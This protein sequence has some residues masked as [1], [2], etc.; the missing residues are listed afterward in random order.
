[1]ARKVLVSVALLVAFSVFALVAGVPR[2]DLLIVQ[3]AH[4]RVPNPGNT[5]IFT[6]SWRYPDR[7]LH[8]LVFRPLWMVDPAGGKVINVLAESKPI[9]N[10]DFTTMTVKLR[11]GI[12]WSDGVEFTADD[13]VYAVKLTIQHEG[14]AYHTQLSEWVKDVKALDR[15]TVVFDLK[16]PNPRFHYYFVDRWGCWRPFPKHIFEKVSDPVKFSFY[17]PIGTGAYILKSYDPAGYW[18]LY[19]R[20]KDW[21]R[22]PVGVLYGMPKPRYIL[23]QAYNS[24]EQMVL[25]MRKH[26][27]DVAYTF[28][29]ELLRSVLKIPTV[30]SF[31]KDFPWGSFV[32]PT[33][34]GI[35]LNTAKFPFNIRDVRWALTLSVNIVEVADLVLNGAVRLAP[36]HVPPTPLYMKYYYEPLKS[37]LENFEL[38][39]GNG[40][41]FKPFD[42]TIPEKLAKLAKE[43]GYSVP[44]SREELEKLFGIGW[45]K[46]A[47]DVAAKLLE[48][49][50]FKRNEKGQ[51]LLPNGQPWKIE[52][53]VN[54]DPNRADNRVPTAIAQQWQKFG[55]QV[56]IRPNKNHSI[57]KYGRFDASSNWPAVEPWGGNID[58]YR[59]IEPFA[60]KYQRPIGE[61]NP[62]HNSRWSN[63]EMDEI[64][65]K[66]EK[67][68][69]FNTNETL[70]LGREALKVL[71]QEMPTIPAFQVTWLVL[72]DEY[73]WTN[74]STAE[75]P[76]I[77]PVHT[78]PTFGFEMPFLKQTG[79]K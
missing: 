61:Y 28:S 79:K 46:Y 35:T 11:K 78:W 52:V 57:Y 71:V 2:S 27:L 63:P 36:L 38:Q 65:E 48:K 55:I 14:M 18:F 19:E 49:H 22:T 43:K 25:A 26:Q 3:N 70:N 53:F 62:G 17:P 66:M 10:S 51:W 64:I 45:W 54:A 68:S 1:M 67:T 72:Y 30:R 23:F 33:V 31:R 8:Q 6:T 12:Y 32:E 39:I 41:K 34:A 75:N 4:G 60:S 76:Y 16:K 74:W 7:G 21:Q 42:P 13:V 69:P 29:L 24:P 40:E 58:L 20:R 47:P 59:T 37:F 9:Y 50:G 77:Q 15:Y 44:D 5:N 73:Y 56:D